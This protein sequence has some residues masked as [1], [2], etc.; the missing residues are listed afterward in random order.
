MLTGLLGG[1]VEWHVDVDGPLRHLCSFQ[2][3]PTGASTHAAHAFAIKLQIGVY[4]ETL[5]IPWYLN[6]SFC[7]FVGDG[8][9]D[10]MLCVVFKLFYP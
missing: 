10:R 4:A 8:L 2:E 5:D 6:C 1:S 7:Q 3:D 9:P